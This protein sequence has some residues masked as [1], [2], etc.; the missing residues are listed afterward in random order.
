MNVNTLLELLSLAKTHCNA[1]K[2]KATIWRLKKGSSVC[3]FIKT[4]Q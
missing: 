4:D 1:K 2:G 3:W